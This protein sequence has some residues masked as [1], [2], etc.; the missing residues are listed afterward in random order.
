MVPIP[1]FGGIGRNE[2]KSHY[3]GLIV[4]IVHFNKRTV[5]YMYC[6]YLFVLVISKVHERRSVHYVGLSICIPFDTGKSID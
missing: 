3:F 1:R 6:T 4:K 2:N 5:Y